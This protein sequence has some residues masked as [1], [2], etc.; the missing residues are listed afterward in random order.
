MRGVCLLP[1]VGSDQAFGFGVWVSLSA[2]NFARYVETFED[3]DQSKLGAMFGWLSNRLP[4]YPDTINLQT[5][6]V[7]QDGGAR[8]Q[9]WINEAHAEHPL[10][11][12]QHQGISKKRLGKIYAQEVCDRGKTGVG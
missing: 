10:Y 4:S 1:V 5:T 11:Q 7:P 9:V 8:P 6:V 3:D 2:D 12:E